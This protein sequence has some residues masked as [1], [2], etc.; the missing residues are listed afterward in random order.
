MSWERTSLCCSLIHS[1]FHQNYFTLQDGKTGLGNALKMSGARE[2][3][4]HITISHQCGKALSAEGLWGNRVRQSIL[5]RALLHSLRAWGALLRDSSV[6]TGAVG[7]RLLKQKGI[8]TNLTAATDLII[9]AQ[10]GF[11]K[12]SA[13][14]IQWRWTI[15]AL[16]SRLL[17]LF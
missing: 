16:P 4:S 1:R 6:I 9:H 15:S 17:S 2:S 10:L 14:Q 3:P 12:T 13:L 8:P 7:E 11:F 5:L